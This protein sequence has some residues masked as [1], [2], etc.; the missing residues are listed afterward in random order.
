MPGESLN[1][2]LVSPYD[3][4]TQGGVTE[5]IRHLSRELRVQGHQT[6]I[7]APF[8]TENAE[9][10]DDVYA[11]GAVTPVPANGSVARISLST[12]L[13]RSI[14]AILRTERF[15]L[16]HVHE[17]MMPTVPWLVLR[18]S[19]TVNVGTF[20]AFGDYSAMYAMGRPILR[21]F[22]SKLQGRIAVSPSAFEYVS[23]YFGGDFEI[24]PNGV[25]VPRF[26]KKLE[27]V[28]WINDG[29]PTILF[30]GRFEEARKG[31]RWLLQALPLVEPYF[32]DLRVVVAGKG[33]PESV[34]EW[35]PLRDYT[36]RN[37]TIYRSAGS[38]LDVEFTGFV[39]A[40]DLPRLY[41]SC[42]IY[43]APSTGGESF[44]IVLLEG[45]AAGT[46]LLASR[47]PGYA[48]VLT[49]GREGFL[50]EPKNP[51]SIAAGLIRL[52]SDRQLRSRMGEAGQRTA[53]QYDWPIIAGR[54][55]DYYR[56]TIAGGI[57]KGDPVPP[58]RRRWRRAPRGADGLPAMR[59]Y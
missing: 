7:L 41:Q 39:P 53:R 3:Y 34:A 35:L 1:I 9:L 31:L 18:A 50:H 14:K 15:D 44:G 4:A 43:C 47:I 12:D 29:R 11:L 46:A 49:H 45:M 55:V 13:G 30:V 5:H 23:Q 25:D 59:D 19:T 36:R 2:G 16:I 48:N 28:A 40:A 56:Q 42:D 51:P 6:K 17:P 57:R 58:P 38:A 24:V 27:P 21:R 10:P 37:R 32:P 33:D 54:L 52:L 26:E 22:Y 20:H 8:S